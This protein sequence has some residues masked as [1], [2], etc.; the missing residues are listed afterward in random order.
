MKN[1]LYIILILIITL[2]ACSKKGVTPGKETVTINGKV[3]HT[4]VIGNRTWTTTNY[5]GPGGVANAQ[6]ASI[7]K[8]YLLSEISSI[9]LPAG[10][11]IPTKAD[12]IELLKSQGSPTIN[13]AGQT[14]A[15]STITRYLMAASQWSI[16]GDDRS[17]LNILPSGEYATYSSFNSKNDEAKFWSSTADTIAGTSFQWVLHVIGFSYTYSTNPQVIDGQNAYVDLMPQ[18]GYAYNLRFVKDN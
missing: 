8:F 10:W 13:S 16:P 14:V 11:R 9:K 18:A 15:D 7:G 1:L 12:F 3:Y 4:I 17:G 2:F 5:D 6:E